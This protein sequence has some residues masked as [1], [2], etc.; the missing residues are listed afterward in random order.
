[1][2]LSIPLSILLLAASALATA[3]GPSVSLQTPPGFAVLPKQ[4]EYLYRAASAD[5][6]VLAVRVEDNKPTGNLP[7]SR[8]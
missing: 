3:C 7:S 5:G 4:T 2:K 1:M 8:G 6:V